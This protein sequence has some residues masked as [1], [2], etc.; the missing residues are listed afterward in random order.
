MSESCLLFATIIFILLEK[1]KTSLLRLL[2]LLRFSSAS[3]PAVPAKPKSASDHT[4]ITSRTKGMLALSM[5]SSAPSP[6][7]QSKVFLSLQPSLQVDPPSREDTHTRP[8]GA[9]F[10]ALPLARSQGHR[11]KLSLQTSL[12]PPSMTDLTNASPTARN[13]LTNTFD[14]SPQIPA[15]AV[16]PT[17]SI[18]PSLAVPTPP[19]PR[20]AL[21]SPFYQDTPYLLPLTARSI[22]RN[23]PLPKRHLSATSSTRAHKRIFFPIKR[24]SFEEKTA[25]IIPPA[26]FNVTEEEEETLDQYKTEEER[27]E[28]RAIIQAEDSRNGQRAKRRKDWIWRPMPEESSPTKAPTN[29]TVSENSQSTPTNEALNVDDCAINRYDLVQ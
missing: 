18:S 27:E 26:A 1:V 9:I 5:P 11:P 29:S 8:P 4:T 6:H 2:F 25:D 17:L 23:S 13:T 19:K 12:P 21:S 14:I 16:L 28:R 20:S 7:L 3:C 15:S 22:L 24:V 10:S